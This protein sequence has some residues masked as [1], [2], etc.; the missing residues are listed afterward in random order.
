VLYSGNFEP[1]Q[2]VGMLVEAA[3]RVERA[4]FVF[5]GGEA[6]EIEALREQARASGARCVFSGKRPPSELPAFLGLADVLVSPRLHG[7]NTPFKVYTYLASGKPLVATRIPTHTQ[8]L[9]DSLAFLVA[10][11]AEALAEGIRRALSAPGEAQE[12]AAAARA[13]VQREYSEAR[14]REKVRAAYEDVSA[15]VERE[16]V[17]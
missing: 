9:D 16:T 15:D 8:L 6:R 5:M 10:P 14:Y 1:Y 13:L 12:K 17:G 4:Q 2:G 7:E 3:A 11:T